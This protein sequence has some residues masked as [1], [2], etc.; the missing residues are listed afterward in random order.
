M[1]KGIRKCGFVKS[2]VLPALFIQ[3]GWEIFFCHIQISSKNFFVG[4]KSDLMVKIYQEN[5]NFTKK[6]INKPKNFRALYL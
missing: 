1:E 4:N 2:T 6:P 3:F 5:Q